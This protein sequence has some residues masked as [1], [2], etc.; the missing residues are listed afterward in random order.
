M[1][2]KVNKVEFDAVYLPRD[3]QQILFANGIIDF[4]E[5]YLSTWEME[6]HFPLA[7][8]KIDELQSAYVADWSEYQNLFDA[9]SF[10]DT[11]E[12]YGFERQTI[13]KQVWRDRFASQLNKLSKSL[14][15]P[16]L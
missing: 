16:V 10:C 1:N 15:N 6:I 2:N 11:A 8:L 12:I 4:H 13:L 3:I 14:P 9:V 5:S 7:E